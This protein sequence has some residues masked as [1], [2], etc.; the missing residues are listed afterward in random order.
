MMTMAVAEQSEISKKVDK[1]MG[2]MYDAIR[3]E[4]TNSMESGMSLSEVSRQTGIA[5]YILSQVVNERRK[6]NLSLTNYVTI[7]EALDIKVTIG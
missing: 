4:L 2:R 7:C 6:N 5:R 3:K 1:T